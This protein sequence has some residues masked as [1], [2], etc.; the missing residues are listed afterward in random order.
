MPVSKHSNAGASRITFF[1]GFPYNVVVISLPQ[2]LQTV[3]GMSPIG[4]GIRLMPYTFSGSLAAL[5][6]N[7]TAGK[8]KMPL[9]YMFLFGALL[10]VLGL[11]LLSR[12]PT[13]NPVPAAMYGYEILTGVGFGVTFAILMLGTPFVVEKRDLGECSADHIPLWP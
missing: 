7:I 13:N 6:A 2:R 4:A 3:S 11:G 5:A 10:Q 1:V 8:T 12:L 9:I